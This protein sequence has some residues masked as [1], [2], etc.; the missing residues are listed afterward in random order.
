MRHPRFAVGSGSL[1]VVATLL[2]A[3]CTP[4]AASDGSDIITVNGSEPRYGLIPANTDEAG[5]NRI[6]D[7]I[8]A[9][10]AFYDDSGA[11]VNDLAE[12]IEHNEKNTVYTVSID[13]GATFTN[14]EDVTADSFVDAWVWAAMAENE[15]LNRQFFSDI[16]GYSEEEDVS[17][18][19]A[20]GLTVIDSQTFEIHLR[21]PLS[22]FAQRLGHIAFSPLPQV[23]FDD[24]IAFGDHPV[25]NGPYMLDGGGAWQH[26]ERIELVVNPG[27]EGERK[28]ENGGVTMMF[29]DSLDTAYA[30]LLTGALDVL[31]TIPDS[32]RPTF[33]EELGPR[34]I[35][36][37]VTTLES[38]R[39]PAKL[40]HFVGAEGALRRAAISQAIDRES[41]VEE[42]F[43]GTRIPAADFA[44]PA[45]HDFSERLSGS[46]ML[47]FNSDDAVEKWAK[48][49]A[50]SPWEGTFE[51]AYNAD[52]DHG[53]WVDSVA[54]SIHDVLGIDVVGVPYP[55]LADLKAAITGDGFAASYRVGWRADYPGV[56]NFI[57]PLYSA[58]GAGNDGKYSSARFEAQMKLGAVAKSAEDADDAYQGAQEILLTDLPGL[59]LWNTTVQAGYGEAVDNVALD[60]R[61]TPFYYQITRHDG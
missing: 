41:I 20:G 17:L 37:P 50:L 60:W 48:A 32:A 38:L 2:L 1:A 5:G 40:P 14:G 30:D 12:T 16:V 9:G 46:E 21:A 31:D 42:V 53:R 8:F 23:F 56:V 28:P 54:E 59:P 36:Q 34:W 44:S 10:L 18:E 6:V 26:G 22:D 3:G 15:T 4:G 25:G 24:P 57:A 45:L 7:A 35:D 19:E 13:D 55:T 39:I 58:K 49:D 33:K 29:Y 52:G 43:A 51:I 11:V 61:G 27:Y 47:R